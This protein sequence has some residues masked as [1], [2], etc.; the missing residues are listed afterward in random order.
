MACHAIAGM[1]GG[2]NTLGPDLSQT[3][4]DY[5]EEG[6]T[7][8]LAELPFP[9]MKPIYDTRPVTPEEQAHLKAFLRVSAELEPTGT[10][11]GGGFLLF[12][13]GGGVLLIGLA[14]VV[15]R[16]RLSEVRRMLLRRSAK[17]GGGGG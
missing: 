8:V 1:P 2:S 17:P 15:W 6:L 7:S 9:S 5:G 13:M 11:K 3:Y 16:K 10:G 4:V 14:H 12:G